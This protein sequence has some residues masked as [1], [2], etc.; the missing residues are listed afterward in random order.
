MT[1]LITDKHGAEL[2]REILTQIEAEVE[3][4][5]VCDSSTGESSTEGPVWNQSV[6]AVVDLD[7][8]PPRSSVELIDPATITARRSL[9]YVPNGRA[10]R[11]GLAA[12]IDSGVG[13][14][15]G[16]ALCFAGHA[17]L[18]AGDRYLIPVRPEVAQKLRTGRVRRSLRHFVNNYRH[19][20]RDH[21]A[22]VLSTVITPDNE[23]TTVEIRARE[24]LGLTAGEAET[25]FAGG[26]TLSDLRRYVEMMEQG[27]HL[28]TGRPKRGVR[29][30]TSGED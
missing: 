21:G 27:L 8:L 1:R 19:K 18:M 5:L 28:V 9:D 10:V 24:L 23:V 17:S 15:C 29:R 4:Q 7:L 12:A 14:S 2:A 6:W 22:K 13:P 16:T 3:A 30:R 20:L 26:N 11:S 25:L